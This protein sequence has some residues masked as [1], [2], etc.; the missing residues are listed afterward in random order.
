LVENIK[1]FLLD[2]ASANTGTFD[3][4]LANKPDPEAFVEWEVPTLS[5]SL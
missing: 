4:D 3:S 1:R 5:G 2:D